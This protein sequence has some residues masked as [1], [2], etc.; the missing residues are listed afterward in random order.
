MI[1]NFPVSLR[2]PIELEQINLEDYKLGAAYCRK[3]LLKGGD[4]SKYC[5]EQ[6][7]EACALKLELTALHINVV[8]VYRAPYGNFNSSLNGL[9]SIIKSLLLDAML[10]S[11]NLTAT[12][13][14]PTRVQNE[15]NVAINYIFIDNY[16]FTKYTVSLIYIYIMG[17]SDHDNC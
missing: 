7:I 5:K 11:Y 13:H 3:S 15:S 10:L 6:D 8:T 1:S 9:D 17:Y 4:L 14:F 16:K 2:H 12:V